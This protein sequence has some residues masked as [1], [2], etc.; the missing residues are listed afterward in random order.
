MSAT[1]ILFL[2]MTLLICLGGFAISIF[3]SM[4]I[5]VGKREVEEYYK[6]QE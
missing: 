2:I 1:G 4:K 5:S 3:L 6:S